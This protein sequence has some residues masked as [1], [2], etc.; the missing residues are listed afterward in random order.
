MT[1][2]PPANETQFRVRYAE[3]DQMGVAYYANYLV[4]MELGRV[5]YCRAAGLRYRDM[6]EKDGVL[7]AVVE[8]ACRY[9][10]PA[11]Y[12]DEIAV[13]TWIGA[14][15]PRLVRFDYEMREAQSG[16]V[17]ATGF[18]RHIFC[19]E[20]MCR[21]VLPPAYWSLFGIARTQASSDSTSDASLSSA[22]GERKNRV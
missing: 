1:V 11:R 2:K 9:K 19:K 3:T 20:G 13:R 4:W 21:T 10:S 22:S 12:D 5:E 15:N 16:R 17:L 8:A 18:T 6:E 7:L 14:A